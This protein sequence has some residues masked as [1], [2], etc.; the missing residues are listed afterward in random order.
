MEHLKEFEEIALHDHSFAMMLVQNTIKSLIDQGLIT[1][2]HYQRSN[3]NEEEIDPHECT[4]DS[5]C[6][7]KKQNL[8]K[9]GL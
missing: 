6:N 9:Q 3:M 1:D 5:V 7:T 8:L 4:M 2:Q